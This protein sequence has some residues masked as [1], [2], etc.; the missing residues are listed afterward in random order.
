MFMHVFDYSFLKDVPF[1]S[2]MITKVSRIESLRMRASYVI[3]EHP[4]VMRDMEA[5]AKVMSVRGSNAIEGIVTTDDRIIA[6]ANGS[7]APKGHSES[8]IAGY[9]DA[10]EIVHAR[11]D[12]LEIEEKTILRLFSV[13][14]AQSDGPTG[15]K[16]RDNA[17]MDVDPDGT[18]RIRFLPASAAEVPSAMEQLILAYRDARDD[19]GINNLLLIP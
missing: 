3:R 17:I 1:S 14:N 4:D 8:E 12:S 16:T 9:R 15:Y 2:D 18:R 10:L 5:V 11:F 6:L 19:T 7:V 13:M